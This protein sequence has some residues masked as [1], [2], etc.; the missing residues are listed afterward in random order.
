MTNGN[1]T[2][3]NIINILALNLA[4]LH[5]LICAEEKYNIQIY[6]NRSK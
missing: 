5:T 4:I 2:K 6:N 1:V 3:Q